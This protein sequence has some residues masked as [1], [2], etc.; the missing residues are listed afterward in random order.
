MSKMRGPIKI[1]ASLACASV[2][3][4]ERD[5]RELEAAGV[6]CFHF[7]MMD[8][9]FV[10]NFALSFDILKAVRE[11]S[12]TPVVCHLMIDQPERYIERTAALAPAYISIHVEATR[13]VQRVL[14]QIRAAG[15]RTGVALNPATPPSVLHYVLEDV[16][17]IT[18][19]TVNPG[20]AGQRLVPSTIGKLADLRDLLDR[21]GHTS[22]ELEVDGNV[23]FENIPQMLHSG[24]TMLV[25]GTSSLFSQTQTIAQ[26][27]A[28]MR[29]LIEDAAVMH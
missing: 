9:N 8:G 21:A 6:D 2:R 15:I 10:P 5:L 23:S 19:M 18:V 17:L 12:D 22:T 16:D 26:A 14:Q 13:H 3:H 1:E 7:D 24:A 20:F 11:M 29:K 28:A 27:T 25:G 4:L